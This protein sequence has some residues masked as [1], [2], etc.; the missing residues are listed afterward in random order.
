MNSDHKAILF[1]KSESYM[2]QEGE[3]QGYFIV[4]NV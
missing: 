3:K 4:I 1:Q 2:R